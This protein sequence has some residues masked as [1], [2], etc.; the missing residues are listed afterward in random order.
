MRFRVNAP[1]IYL[2]CL[3]VPPGRQHNI[4]RYHYKRFVQFFLSALAAQH[5]AVAPASPVLRL[6]LDRQKVIA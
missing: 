6:I 4:Q 2:N 3:S 1:F 5:N